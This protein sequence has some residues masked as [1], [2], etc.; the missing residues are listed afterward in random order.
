MSNDSKRVSKPDGYMSDGTPIYL[1]IARGNGKPMLQLEIYR[2]LCEISDDE[3]A[4]MK[5]E[6]MKDL[7]D[8]KEKEI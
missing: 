4:D 5:A 7:T 1:K 6:I 3:W 8:R 2:K